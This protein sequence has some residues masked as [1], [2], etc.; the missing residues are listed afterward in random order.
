MAQGFLKTSTQASAAAI[1]AVE[2]GFRTTER[3]YASEITAFGQC[4]QTPDFIEGT[5]AF[6]E[7]RK[8]DFS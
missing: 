6:L 2:A 5:G 8:P 7:K 1:Q 4:F 3:G